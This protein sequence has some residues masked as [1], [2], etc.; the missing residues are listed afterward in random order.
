MTGRVWVHP[1][2]IV[3]EREQY[4]SVNHATVQPATGQIMGTIHHAFERPLTIHPPHATPLPRVGAVGGRTVRLILG[5]AMVAMIA[6]AS[7]GFIVG[8]ALAAGQIRP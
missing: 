5:T 3:T 1:T 2:I 4:V 6:G 7:L 8:Y